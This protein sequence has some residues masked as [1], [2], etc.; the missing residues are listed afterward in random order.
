MQNPRRNDSMLAEFACTGT[1]LY[2][3]SHCY[4][5]TS[6]EVHVTAPARMHN[7]AIT[8]CPAAT[9]QYRSGDEHVLSAQQK[10]HQAKKP[11]IEEK[12]SILVSCN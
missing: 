5:Q 1:L 3:K 6:S 8:Q 12:Q 2:S 9:I 10:S 11:L 7:I 4:L